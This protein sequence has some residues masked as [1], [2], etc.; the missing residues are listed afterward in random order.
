M[1]TDHPPQKNTLP[2]IFFSRANVNFGGCYP[3]NSHPCVKPWNIDSRIK[4]SHAVEGVFDSKCCFVKHHNLDTNILSTSVDRSETWK[5]IH[6]WGMM[7]HAA[8]AAWTRSR[9]ASKFSLAWRN[10]AANKTTTRERNEGPGCSNNSSCACATSRSWSC[11]Q[12][13]KMM[14]FVMK[15]W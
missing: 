6:L 2:T 14:N 3:K 4:C 15:T 13:S 10:L 5:N 8:P 7:P 1:K 9:K 12:K 11:N